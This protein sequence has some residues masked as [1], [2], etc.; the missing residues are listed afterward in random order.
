MGETALLIKLEPKEIQMAEIAAHL[1]IAAA[2]AQVLFHGTA[3]DHSHGASV[4]QLRYEAYE[5]MALS[6]LQRIAREAMARWQIHRIAIVHRLGEVPVTQDAVVVGVAAS[7]RTEAFEACR[8]LID[9]LKSSVP[10]WK[11]EILEK[12]SRWAANASRSE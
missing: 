7:H 3:R 11:E 5:E 6:E 12:G 4:L 9:A 8:F 10:I 2:G 1:R